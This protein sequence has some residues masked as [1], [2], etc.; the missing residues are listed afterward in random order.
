M[1]QTWRCDMRDD[2]QTGLLA[3]FI[4]GLIVCAAFVAGFV[5]GRLLL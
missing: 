1:S 5:V 3:A 4:A 2:Y